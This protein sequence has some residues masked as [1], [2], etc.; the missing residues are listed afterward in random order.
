[1]GRRTPPVYLRREDEE[2]L[3]TLLQYAF[4]DPQGWKGLTEVERSILGS[5]ENYTRLV[6]WACGGREN[7]YVTGKPFTF[8]KED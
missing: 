3:K 2:R 8:R 7:P 6:D 5:E 4:A 1:M